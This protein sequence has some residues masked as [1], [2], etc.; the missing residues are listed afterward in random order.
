MRNY[1]HFTQLA[2]CFKLQCFN[3]LLLNNSFNRFSA[4][5]ARRHQSA[6]D[7]AFSHKPSKIASQLSNTTT[8]S[9]SSFC[10]TTIYKLCSLSNSRIARVSERLILI[11]RVPIF[12]AVFFSFSRSHILIRISLC[13]FIFRI[14]SRSVTRVLPAVH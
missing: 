9:H 1:L 14:H 4:E 7:L 3:R 2:I 13:V 10:T 11:R 8:I 5:I 6:S 12:Q